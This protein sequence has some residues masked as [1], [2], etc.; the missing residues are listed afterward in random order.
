MITSAINNM[1]H[2]KILLAIF[3][4]INSVLSFGQNPSTSSF[5]GQIVYQPNNIIGSPSAID[6][7][8]IVTYVKFD[9]YPKFG[10][11]IQ[12][13]RVDK[14][15]EFH[16][17]I[18]YL[19]KV[20]KFQM[21]Y[22]D[23]GKKWRWT[24]GFY[25]EPGDQIKIKIYAK[26]DGIDSISFQG[27]GAEKYNLTN[28]LNNE[29][30]RNYMKDPLITEIQTIKNLKELKDVLER[31]IRL[32]LKHQSKS[33]NLIENSN[34]NYDLKKIL[35]Y[36]FADYHSD[37]VFRLDLLLKKFPQY[38]DVIRDSYVNNSHMLYIPPTSLSTFAPTYI[39]TAVA[40]IKFESRLDSS[41]A[42]SDLKYV[43]DE[44]KTKFKNDIRDKIIGRLI[45]ASMTGIRSYDQ[46]S[47]IEK[48]S[49]I[50]DA[51]QTVTEPHIKETI[52]SRMV[53]NSKK[54]GKLFITD[55][56]TLDNKKFNIESLSGK[57]IL[58]D[59]WFLGCAGCA[60]FHALYEKNIKKKFDTDT[61]FVYLSINIDKKKDD[62]IKGIKSNL[63][64]SDKNTNV[65][66]GSLGVGHP[67]LINY[68][69]TGGPFVMI[70]DRD[71]KILSIPS[72]ISISTENSGFEKVIEKAL[73]R[74]SN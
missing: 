73:M 8:S 24:G 71:M 31:L 66:T 10:G 52:E 54:I 62:W 9:E 7:K 49:I 42:K 26:M 50:M 2:L 60:N 36:E 3:I 14:S 28:R 61:N 18:P 53:V 68:G 56:I 48:D 16:F 74:H 69:I 22:E 46:S 55:F 11:D 5:S 35:K 34:L 44:I 63:Y 64:T 20:H 58:I 40:K 33:N 6:V 21:F 12:T 70:V 38:K 57:V 15:G 47:D 59:T 25:Q 4:S 45:F 37:W 72:L 29:M 32:T 51:Y 23:A 1:T 43:Y 65:S 19:G 30:W 41:S 39:R 17:S 27:E 67:F 13:P